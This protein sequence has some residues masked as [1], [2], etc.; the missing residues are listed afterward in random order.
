MK[1]DFSRRSIALALLAGVGCA[2]IIKGGGPQSISVR[3]TP[4]EASFKIVDLKS[5]ATIVS[6]KTPNMVALNKSAGYFSGGHYQLVIDK[7]GYEQ[8]VMEITANASG[9]YIA[10]NLVFGGILGWLVVDPATGAMWTLSPEELNVDLVPSKAPVVAVE[11]GFKPDLSPEFKPAVPVV[12]ASVV[13]EGCGKDTDCKGS[14]VC[15]K[16]VCVAP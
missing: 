2:S 7:P 14:R 3:S 6:S 12:P 13:T 8:K 15:V 10:G 11:Q 5:G 1:T 4:S 16:H 9:W